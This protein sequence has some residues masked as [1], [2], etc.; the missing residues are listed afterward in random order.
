MLRAPAS[1]RYL[2]EP[3]T[4]SAH[5]PLGHLF[6]PC[7][8]S[9]LVQEPTGTKLRFLY[10]QLFLTIA[11]NERTFGHLKSVCCTDSAKPRL[12]AVCYSSS[13][14]SVR[15]RLHLCLCFRLCLRLSPLLFPL[16][17]A[18]SPF[19]LCL[20][21]SLSSFVPPLSP[22]LSP[23]PF[24]PVSL[25]CMVGNEGLSHGHPCGGGSSV[26]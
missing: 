25:I 14:R 1:G 6:L 16:S 18:L 22:F 4:A 10:V 24:H 20:L 15:L 17:L 11:P 23:D 2:N 5:W 9:S 13:P 26:P 21:L 8:L 12:E 3:E 7:R 19:F